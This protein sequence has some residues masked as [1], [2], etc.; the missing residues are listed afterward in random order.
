[1]RAIQTT[2]GCR[3]TCFGPC[4]AG[5]SLQFL[6]FFF[7]AFPLWFVSSTSLVNGHGHERLG[8]SRPL[9]SHAICYSC[10]LL[11]ELGRPSCKKPLLRRPFCRCLP[12]ETCLFCGYNESV[13]NWYPR[14]LINDDGLPKDLHRDEVRSQNIWCYQ[15]LKPCF[16]MS[17]DEFLCKDCFEED[18]WE[19]SKNFTFW[20]LDTTL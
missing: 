13:G 15:V 5:P 2:L 14:S 11:T 3:H 20:N 18:S 16:F 8:C 4:E 1:M 6:S 7:G 10:L 19:F 17:Y 12:I 9:F